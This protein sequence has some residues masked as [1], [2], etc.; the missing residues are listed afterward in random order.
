ML[1]ELTS[2]VLGLN[3]I[4]TAQAQPPKLQFDVSSHIRADLAQRNRVEQSREAMASPII[5]KKPFSHYADLTVPESLIEAAL[6]R[7]HWVRQGAHFDPQY[8]HKLSHVLTAPF[9]RDRG[10]KEVLSVGVSSFAGSRANRM[11]NIEATLARFDGF[12]IPRGETFSFNEQLGEVTEE[13]GFAWARVLRNGKS[14]W[15]LGGGVCQVSTNVF[16]AALN[17]GL[18]IDD[19]RAHSL[20]F[21]KY[22]PTGLDATIYLGAQ[23]LKF[24]NNTPGD[25]LMKFVMRD[26]K[27]VT[28]FYGTRDTR[29]ITLEKTKHWEGF[30]GRTATHWNR[31]VQ[32]V[33]SATEDTFISNYRPDPVEEVAVAEETATAE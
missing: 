11:Q 7:Q 12:I 14:A 30:D 4:P 19:R 13:A 10:I 32:Y 8:N 31:K 2:F 6:N 3:S 18:T 33:D 1:L 9:L 27:M 28:V 20:I 22:A 17:A 5:E 26:Q 16:R 21:E 15:G 24:T 25:V 23:D 29:Q